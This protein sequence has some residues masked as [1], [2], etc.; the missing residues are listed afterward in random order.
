MWAS[1]WG[2]S[3]DFGIGALELVLAGFLE[4]LNTVAAVKVEA[5]LL[6]ILNEDLEFFV[7]V[8]VLLLENVYVLLEG[9]NFTAETSISV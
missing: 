1:D 5:N 8:A 6:V 7:K 3:L 2:G 4:S 9:G